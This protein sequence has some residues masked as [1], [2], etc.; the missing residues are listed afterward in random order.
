[1]AA[2]LT[3]VGVGFDAEAVLHAA[4]PR[5]LVFGSRQG[6]ATDAVASLDAGRPLAVVHPATVRLTPEPVASTV[7]PLA[8][9]H[10]ACTTP[11]MLPPVAPPRIKR[12]IQG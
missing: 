2:A 4:D 12:R 1:V 6:A 5:S 9:I 8:G 3:V 7:R 10:V 11:H